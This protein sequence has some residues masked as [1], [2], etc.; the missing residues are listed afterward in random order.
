MKLF[1]RQLLLTV[2]LI[3][4]AGYSIAGRPAF[5]INSLTNPVITLYEGQVGT[6][7]Y[8][9]T[10]NTPITL[11]GNGLIN[12]QE[13]IRQNGGSCATPF[14]LTAGA[15]CTVSLQITANRLRSN[16][17][18]GPIVCHT[19]A[20][21]IN[22]AQP[23]AGQQI[24]VTKRNT[25]SP[26]QQYSIG[27]TITGLSSN[28]L[29]LRNNGSN[30]L[31]VMS[32]ATS[33][34]FA[35]KVTAGDSYNVTVASQPTGLVC[36]VNNGSG[37]NVN[38]NISSITIV[39]NPLSYTIGGSIT[40]LTA[41]GLVLRNNGGD[42]LALFSGDTSFVFS[43][44]VAAGASYN[45]TVASQPTGLTCTVSNGSNINVTANVTSVSITCSTTNFTIGG[46]ISG[47]SAS[48]LV[49]RNNGADDLLVA[50]GA[51]TFQFTTPV[52]YAGSYNV[53]VATQ[54]AGLTCTV[55]NASG[56]NVTSNIN[57]ITVTCAVSTYT[58][59]GTITGLSASG[60]VLRNNGG[61]DL[62]VPSGATS[63]QFA[64]PVA[65][66]SSYNV[67]VATQPTGL[68]CSVSNDSGINV[69]A[70][71]TSV[72]ITCNIL[73]YTIGGSVTGLS[74]SGLVLRNNGGDD[75]VVASGASTFQFATPVA[76]A[77]S[78]NVTV[79]TQPTGL[80]C[81][82]SNASGINVTS[83]VSSVI[84][85]CS[86][87]NYTIGGSISGLT[88]S[89]LVLRNNGG[90][91]LLVPAGSTSFQFATPV[92]YGS[93]YNVT[94]ATQPNSLTCT[95]T[96][97]SDTNVTANVTSVS[98]ICSVNTYT[99]GG[100]ITGLS[101]SGLV[102]R[103]NGGDDLL[104]SPGDVAFQFATPIAYGSGYN[105]TVATQPTGYTCTV[106]NG[107]GSNVTA[108]ITSV[109]IS[110]T[111][112][113]YT[114]GGSVSG[115]TANGLVLQNN[116]GDNL[117]VNSGAT[118]FQFVTPVNYNGSYSV[119]V[120]TQPTG[121]TCT[122]S[123]GSGSN[124]SA[125]ITS[126]SINCAVNTY[127][128]GGSI[129]GLA[130]S[131]LVLQN[132]GGD[133]LTVSS[134]ATT[135]QFATPVNYGDGYNVTIATQP[136][137]ATCVVSNGTGS[138]V[139]ADI[140]SVSISCTT[141]TYTIGG[142][143]SGLIANGMVLQNNG[144]DNLSVSSGATTFQFATPVNYNGSYNVTVLTQAPGHTCVVTNGSGSGVTGN[145]TSVSISCTVVT[146]LTGISPTSGTASGGASVTLS[147][148]LLTGATS[149]TFGGSAATF[150][151]VVNSSTVT[152]VTPKVSAGVVNVVITAPGG[153]S[154]LTNA[155]TFQA[156]AIGQSSGGGKI[157]CLNGGLVNMIAT[158]ANIST[159]TGWGGQGTSAG[160]FSTTN[161]ATNTTTIVTAL[162]TGTTYA[163]R[164][165][166]DY[167][168]DSQGNTPCQA[169]NAC[170]NDWFLPAGNST[171]AS[172]QINCLYNNRV[173]IGGFSAISYWSSTEI[174]GNTA[175]M[176]NF[177]D[178]TIAARLKGSIITGTRCVRN[179][180]P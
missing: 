171:A 19:L 23:P 61:D 108:N 4:I 96:N 140:T 28:G 33:F 129:T 10:N 137:G 104:V 8:K 154:T 134:I 51:T 95:V 39:C 94:V 125:D 74:A 30:D 158:N 83:D 7:D 65:Y 135:F 14:N 70:D 130:S 62:L 91:D 131:G 34:Q 46:S 138:N 110:C 12:L 64:T 151:N 1:A 167:E 122:V 97:G 172:S 118:S 159:N 177:V 174:T 106:S 99:I 165:C 178:G 164:L 102:L 78:Y 36:T 31:P 120:F 43:M 113:T 126:V 162:G 76:Y 111:I 123:N 155:Y 127:T 93:S 21:P 26:V 77:G 117:T 115:L 142:S 58:I 66:G 6:I 101:T 168:I 98:I 86:V 103:N 175:N 105:V 163:A 55:S 17:N 24:Q 40:G 90:D 136:T 157:A 141:N 35:Q 59:G 16:V 82:V 153:T 149:V 72:S 81:T 133:D 9:I 148:V 13:G 3:F 63:F 170:Y 156:T 150:V 179:F 173:A 128:I 69:T 84:I 22:C 160:A 88:D 18:G 41:N 57:S 47:L 68:T 109:S 100:S 2:L 145:I 42:D 119:T 45:V 132:N 32:G 147:G 124:V 54:P 37:I 56:I 87:S 112:N 38:E 67:T 180:T 116:S 144:G 60:L 92:A 89:G 85:T 50:S 152:V 25:P 161:G 121:I 27:G 143:I 73:S 49:L 52:A 107:S 5:L 114:I 71:I 79:A 20:N 146:T 44:P 75:L 80:T 176:Q 29:V 48:G 53:T 11:N 15:S 169:G 166:S 139:T